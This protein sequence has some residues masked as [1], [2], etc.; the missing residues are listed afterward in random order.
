MNNQTNEN[1]YQKSTIYQGTNNQQN[2][3]QTYNHNGF[4]W[5]VRIGIVFA[6]I[7]HVFLLASLMSLF[8]LKQN[9]SLWNI[10]GK[11]TDPNLLYTSGYFALIIWIS[12]SLSKTIL[13]GQKLLKLVNSPNVDEK[14][15][16]DKWSFIL[17]GLSLGGLLIPIAIR[18]M[19]PNLE[20]KGTINSKQFIGKNFSLAWLYGSAL[21]I[22]LL[23]TF[24]FLGNI[25]ALTN[26]SSIAILVSSMILLLSVFAFSIVA[27]KI[28]NKENIQE[29]MK[30]KT[31]LGKIA[32]VFSWVFL[33]VVTIEL[34]INILISILHIIQ[35]LAQ[36]L[37]SLRTNS[38]ISIIFSLFR[39]FYEIIYISMTIYL[40]Q[41][42]IETIR[43]LW[44]AQLNND[45][46]VIFKRINGMHARRY[47]ERLLKRNR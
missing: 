26:S 22:I 47:E 4:K 16:N 32:N 11:Y 29:E 27:F 5:L 40:I 33:I 21:S 38:G 44:R 30:Q 19:V 12:F 20:T 9:S 2:Y 18:R 31:Q 35:S 39:V 15:L 1:S 3:Y 42:I 37:N 41:I 45:G 10:F 25:S 13:F 23:L 36:M 43:S 8:I 7:V 46:V 24:T 34:M 6:V 17:L 14:L 28:F